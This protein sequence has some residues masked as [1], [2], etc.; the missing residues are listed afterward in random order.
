MS[1]PHVFNTDAGSDRLIAS[2][3]ATAR[4]WRRVA[5][6]LIDDPQYAPALSYRRV[7]SNRTRSCLRELLRRPHIKYRLQGADKPA[8]FSAV[9]I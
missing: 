2:A 9:G 5:G 7:Y 8:L 3:M 4:R 6:F 1:V